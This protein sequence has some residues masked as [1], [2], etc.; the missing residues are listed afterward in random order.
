[1]ACEAYYPES[2]PCSSPEPE[3]GTPLDGHG[4]AGSASAPA[5]GHRDGLPF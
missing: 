2:C 1:M 3:Q 4:G 5:R